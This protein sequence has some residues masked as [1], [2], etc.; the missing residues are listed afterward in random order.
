MLADGELV[1]DELI[2]GVET[3]REALKVAGLDDAEVLVVAQREVRRTFLRAVAH[4]HVI[5]LDHARAGGLVIPVGVGSGCGTGVV[6]IFLHRDAVEHSLSL[7]V[8]APVVMVAQAVGVGIH[9]VVHIA[10]PHDLTKLFGVE[11]VHLVAVHRSSH[12]CVEVYLQLA[13]LAFLCG[14]DDHTVGSTRT[15]D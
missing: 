2:L 11:H 7:G 5:V 13:V 1:V 4:A 10:L 3:C 14:D 12:R 15:V 8:V 9:A 6:E